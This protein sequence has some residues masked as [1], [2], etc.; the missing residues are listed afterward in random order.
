MLIAGPLVDMHCLWY[1][2]K[3]RK[4][5]TEKVIKT[6]FEFRTGTLFFVVF[7]VAY[8]HFF[9]SFC[10]LLFVFYFV[11]AIFLSIIFVFKVK[12]T[13]WNLVMLYCYLSFSLCP[14]SWLQT[15][16]S[17]FIFC[18]TYVC[19]WPVFPVYAFWVWMLISEPT[20]DMH[21]LWYPIKGRNWVTEKVIQTSF[22][23]PTGK[24]FLIKLN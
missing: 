7:F 20:V 21:C 17:P 4:W 15:A 8:S 3:G 16:P 14:F 23:F 5:M 2:I 11:I 1:P 22:E 19:M 24:F 10:L 12:F 6:S 9:F 18:F 13:S